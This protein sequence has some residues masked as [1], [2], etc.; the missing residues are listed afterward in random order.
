MQTTDKLK[1]PAA[2]PK[3]RYLFTLALGALGIVYG[4]IGT[5]PLYALR[6]SFHTSHGLLPTPANVLGILS[7]IFWSLVL[8]ISVKYLVFILRADHNGEGG[9]LALTSLVTPMQVKRGGGRWLLILLGLFGTALL[10]GDGV[11]TPAISVLSAV[12]GLEVATPLFEPFILP[13]TIGILAALFL[14]Q[15]FGTGGI[16]KVFGPVTVMWFVTLA[17][18]GIAQIVQQ[19]GVLAAANPA[20]ALTFFVENGWR[21]FLVLGSVF[22][23]VTGGEA[24][25]ADMGHF[26]RR[27]IRLVWFTVVL[28]ALL[29]NYFGQAALI[30]REPEAVENPFYEMVPTWGL[31]PVVVLATMAT[32]IASQALISGAFSLTAQ[33]V[34]LGYLP[35]VLIQHTSKK[36]YG[37][38]Y[39]PAVNWLLMVACIGLVLGFRSSSNLA[40]AYGVAVTMTM[41]ITTILFYFVA[42]ERWGW[43]LWVTAPLALFF[44]TFD[45]AFF[46][47]NALKIPQ[48]GWF[49]LVAAVAIFTLMT[50]WKRG[51]LIL[52]E[53]LEAQVEPLETFLEQVASNSPV[54]VPG[55]A[56]YM[57]RKLGGTPFSLAQNLRMNKSL[58]E[59]VILLT[60]ET[61][62]VP[63]IRRGRHIA[64]KNLGNGFVKVV[65]RYG[66]M[67]APN[68]HKALGRVYI[69]GE[70]PQADELVYFVGRETLFATKHPGM[71]LWREKLFA[72]MFKNALSA[73][74]FYRLPPSQVIELGAQVEL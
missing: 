12:E 38:I 74:S 19:P 32:V 52:A 54:R 28:P 31:Y 53:R 35:R 40:A 57:S 39:I 47:A 71:A 60:V 33:A 7:L 30:L 68:V 22:L 50:T 43:P 25:Y 6:E 37:Q 66:F 73:S 65:L 51:R 63:H 11:I 67:E 4:D 20:H 69:D 48:G 44:L 45:V 13:I 41:T 8:V 46:A 2:P 70:T 61:E 5:S 18:L 59:Q 16:G 14:A 27:P 29:L 36:E 9:I 10:Y 55:T 17:I 56:V 64:A 23:V 24:L 21:G 15:R 42:R 26:G 49:P 58:H 72:L 34:Q 1:A 3:G 62:E